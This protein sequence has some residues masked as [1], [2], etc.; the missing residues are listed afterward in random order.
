M[1]F[2]DLDGG[3][4]ISFNEYVLT[5]VSKEDLLH[6]TIVEK[7]F[8]IID[9]DKGGTIGFDELLEVVKPDDGTAI[10]EESWKLA[11]GLKPSEEI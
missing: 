3:G 5:C 11:W 4:S 6:E 9:T 10:P 8:L 2:V 7:A 1:A